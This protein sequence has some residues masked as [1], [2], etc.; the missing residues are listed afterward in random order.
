MNP[1]DCETCIPITITT[2]LNKHSLDKKIKLPL[3]VEFREQ[4]EIELFV[5]K[6]HNYFDGLLGLDIL[7]TLKAK[8][9]LGN[10]TIITNNSIIPLQFKPNFTSE[11]IIAPPC[12]KLIVKVPVDTRNG[13]YFIWKTL[14]EPDLYISEGI[15]SATEWLSLVEIVNATDQE[16]VVYIEQ[17]LK[18]IP[19]NDQNF[20]EVNNFNIESTSVDPS[21]KI[22][23]SIRTE[24]LNNE[25]KKCL[26]T[27]CRK[28]EDIFFNESE[29]LTFSNQIKHQIRTTDD[30]PIFTK[31]YRYPYVHKEEVRKQIDKML[32]QGIIKPSFSP[33]SAPVWIVPKKRDASNVQKWRLV[34][35]Y[36]KLN[37]K[38]ISD[39]YP[40]PNISDILD[41]L[42]RSLYFTTLD[43]ASGF[44]QIEM[45]P[46]DVGKT[47]FTVDG[48]HFEFVRMPFGLKN[49]PSTFQRI[50]DN[51]LKDLIGTVCLVY[52]DDI[53]VYS[54]SL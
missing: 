52:L 21:N 33:W 8:V 45:H 34:I 14:L 39:K 24:H 38:T 42:G 13:D 53:I 7:N 35:D 47:A 22:I 51:V 11:K 54:T 23:E 19:Y 26:L 50:M 12:S 41:K 6:F 25:E 46:K 27:L 37:D 31:S 4:G 20:I 17:P 3:F 28:F 2:I 1:N 44:H 32:S 10:K 30:T 5:F 40:I 48:G 15:Y 16:K 18:T 43:L 49:A 36:R 29:P 9:D